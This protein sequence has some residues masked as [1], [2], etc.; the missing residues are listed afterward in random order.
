MYPTK[1]EILE[2]PFQIDEETLDVINVWK[3]QYLKNLKKKTNLKKIIEISSLLLFL[4]PR[5]SV[6]I[7]LGNTYCYK[8]TSPTIVLNKHKPS[9]ISA[10]HEL[11]HHLYGDS[12]LEACR[13]SIWIFK[14]CFPEFYE[15]LEW[16]GHL[17]VKKEK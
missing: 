11:G 9:L 17:L 1:K 7:E 15:K 3:I 12:E 8:T 2:S 14:T 13:F 4:T 6:W 5:R 16:K 10:L